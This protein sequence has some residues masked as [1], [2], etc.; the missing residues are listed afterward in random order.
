MRDDRGPA[1]PG[2]RDDRGPARPGARDDR[3]EGG[4]SWSPRTGLARQK[5]G[6]REIA[7]ASTGRRTA[8]G[9]KSGKPGRPMLKV[10]H[11]TPKR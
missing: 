7:K 3:K 1:R 2:P 9:S 11:K 8:A 6:A 5:A 10:S 4:L